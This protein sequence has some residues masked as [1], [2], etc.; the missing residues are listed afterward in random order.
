MK[1][2]VIKELNISSRIKKALYFIFVY[3]IFVYS[4]YYL[5]ISIF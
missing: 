4:V 3:V 1:K 5:A 2:G